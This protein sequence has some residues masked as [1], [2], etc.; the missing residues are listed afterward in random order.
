MINYKSLSISLDIT[1]RK[2]LFPLLSLKS[3]RDSLKRAN[4]YVVCIVA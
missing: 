2:L 1:I 3:K 4:C